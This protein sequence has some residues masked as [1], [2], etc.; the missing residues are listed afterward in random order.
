MERE[1]GS[2]SFARAETFKERGKALIIEKINEFGINQYINDFEI[3][4]KS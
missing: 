4:A 2:G 1:S 3:I